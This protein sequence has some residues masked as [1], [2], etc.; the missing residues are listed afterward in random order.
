M[1]HLSDCQAVLDYF[2]GLEPYT[3][4]SS[5]KRSSATGMATKLQ[6]DGTVFRRSDIWE[7]ETETMPFGKELEVAM[8]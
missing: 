8:P 3:E 1:S 7:I 2:G 4:Q 6:D 5:T